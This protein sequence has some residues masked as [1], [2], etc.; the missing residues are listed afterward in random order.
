MTSYAL[1]VA[2]VEKTTDILSLQSPMTELDSFE[3]TLPTVDPTIGFLDDV[4]VKRDGLLIFRG[5]IERRELS[6]DDT[7]TQMVIAGQNYGA[8]LGYRLLSDS[9]FLNTEPADVIRV[10]LRQTIEA[11]SFIDD[12]GG[13]LNFSA[14]RGTI[15]LQNGMLDAVDDQAAK[16]MLIITT[17]TGAASW[18]NYLVKTYACP[19]SD[20][21]GNKSSWTNVA[22]GLIAGYSDANNYIVAYLGYDPTTS[23]RRFYL[24]KV[25]GGVETVLA[26]LNFDWSYGTTYCMA[27]KVEGTTA[28]AYLDGQKLLAGT[29]P[30]GMNT[31]KAGL[32]SGGLHCIFDDFYVTLSGKT[33]TASLNNASAIN[34]LDGDLDSEW[35][36][37]IAQAADQW[38]KLDLGA[39]ISNVCRITILQD[40]TKYARN[41]KIEVSTDNENWTQLVSRTS[42]HRPTIDLCFTAQNVRYVKITITASDTAQWAICEFGVHLQAGNQILQEATINEYGTALTFEFRGENRLQACMKVAETIGWFFWA[43]TDNKVHFQSSRGTD[44]SSTIKFEEAVNIHSIT[45]TC[46]LDIANYIMVFGQ[47]EGKEQL[48][49]VKQDTESI[50]LY[51]Q[52]DI[53]VV[54]Q[55]LVSLNTMMHY[56]QALLNYLRNPVDALSLDAKETYDADQYSVGDLVTVKSDKVGVNGAYRIHSISR[57]W[58]QDGEDLSLELADQ[59]RRIL[60]P[61]THSQILSEIDDDVSKITYYPSRRPQRYDVS[62]VNGLISIAFEIPPRFAT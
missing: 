33:A 31:G 53:I 29:I 19:L 4:Q 3:A 62:Q 2:G 42:D 45:R 38:F 11:C 26:A 43:D 27:L 50:G 54:Q 51:G 8:K 1:T 56:A 36:S 13:D 37:G 23:A 9:L 58:S 48:A 46:E 32:I 57:T 17:A 16:N 61:K 25:V 59:D 21:L 55:D 10:L 49:I 40:P 5:L 24:S 14:N 20:Y 35:S 52:H 47:G 30:G 39:I 7:G 44:K 6:R 18:T 12:F 41:Y 34:A 22:C 28:Y 60:P 15:A